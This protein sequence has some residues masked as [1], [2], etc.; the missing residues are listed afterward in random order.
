MSEK[1][2]TLSAEFV[3]FGFRT[4][5]LDEKELAACLY[6]ASRQAEIERTQALL[7]DRK[8]IDRN[9]FGRRFLNESDQVE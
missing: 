6:V 5:M 2:Q 9:A 4:A 3:P 8:R 1:L 7:Q